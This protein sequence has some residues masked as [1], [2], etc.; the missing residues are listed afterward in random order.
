MPKIPACEHCSAY[1]WTEYPICFAHPEGPVGDF[2]PDFQPNP[3]A[4]ATA[5]AMVL[6][7]HRAEVIQAA[8][9]T[10]IPDQQLT[11][12]TTDQL[13]VTRAIEQLRTFAR[14]DGLDFQ[15]ILEEA[16][17]L[18]SRTRIVAYD[19]ATRRHPERVVEDFGTTAAA[20]AREDLESSPGILEDL[21]TIYS[22]PEEWQAL[23]IQLEQEVNQR[24]SK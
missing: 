10:R 11:Q 3:A 14:E 6:D 2:C 22:D 12:M 24:L 4:A 18:M 21:A 7:L 9:A 16:V 8:I 1:T 15:T 20:W 5:P 17:A 13:R 19:R 23:M